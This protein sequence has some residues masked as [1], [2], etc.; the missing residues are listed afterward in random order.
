MLSWHGTSMYGLSCCL[1]SGFGSPSEKDVEGHATGGGRGAYTSFSFMGAA[2]HAVPMLLDPEKANCLRAVLLVAIP[3][4]AGKGGMWTWKIDSS[5]P[6]GQ[7]WVL[8]PPVGHAAPASS[9]AS[10]GSTSASAFS[11]D[12]RLDRALAREDTSHIE[13]DWTNASEECKQETSSRAYPLGFAL[14]SAHPSEMKKY[15][16][17]GSRARLH[18][19]FDEELR[20]PV[21]TFARSCVHSSA[22]RQGGRLRCRPRS[23][24]TR[25]KTE[26]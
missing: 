4:P 8:E 6:K 18:V 24:G 2:R 3:G 23:L 10:S 25:W 9:A 19:G 14:L 20:G 15:N 11:S 7:R 21:Q 5:R 16:Y 17:E 1:F 12:W 26:V 13:P 22:H